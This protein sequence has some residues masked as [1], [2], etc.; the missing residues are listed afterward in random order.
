MT[1]SLSTHEGHFDAGGCFATWSATELAVGNALVTRRWRMESGLLFPSSLVDRQA[2][3][4]WLS[5]PGSVPA[6]YPCLPM[7]GP[8]R[9]VGVTARFGPHGPVEMPSLLVKVYV[10]GAALTLTYHLQVFPDSS[11]IT[12]QLL[13]EGDSGVPVPE[14]EATASAATGIETTPVA[15]TIA[16]CQLDALECLPLAPQHLRLTQVIFQDQTDAHNELVREQEWL[17]HPSERGLAL[18]GNLFILEDTLTNHGLIL[19]KAAPLPHA[20]PCKSEVDFRVD[21][22]RNIRFLGHGAGKDGDG[23]YRFAVIPYAG[24]R[25]GC[26][27]ALQQYQR[28][29]RPYQPGRDGQFL[30]NTWGD[31]SRDS[32]IREEFILTEIAAGA[33]LG[34]D[35]VQI[36]D[37]WQ[38][39]RTSNSSVAGGVWEG[40]W[41][42]DARFWQPHAE[43]FPRGLAPVID[44]A[45]A[46]GMQFGLWFAP[47]SAEDFANWE[48]DAATILDLHRVHGVRYFKID[49]VKART[50][51]GE[52]HLHRF[53]DAV[54]SASRGGIV[55]DLDVTAEERPGYFGLLDAG[56]LF[57]ENRYTDWHS[58]WPHQTLRNLW[59]LARY[60][61][62]ARLRMELLNHARHAHL[63][64]DDPLAPACYRP[65][66][67]FAVTMFAN[68]L[69]WFEVSN[70][71]E[72]YYQEA[73]P[74]IAVW[75]A[76]RDTLFAGTIYPIGQA[77]DGVSWTGFLSLDAE[78]GHGYLLVFR[79]RHPSADWTTDLAGVAG[80]YR[81]VPLAGDGEA[82]LLDGWLSVHI[83]APQ[84]YLFIRL[85]AE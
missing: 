57:V 51:Q 71:P 5:G 6:P 68:P 2:G 10:H 76:H 41:G 74:L 13:M 36:D 85:I 14:A 40:F 45:R 4:E 15:A 63:Y 25:A 75:R 53:F 28:Q 81:C 49:G 30:S 72:A 22:A 64:L 44:A 69:G 77:P 39:G 35:V 16:D 8:L 34:V 33:R 67:L 50:K 26:T 23:S 9:M 31:R 79:E 19:L 84:R 3:R 58:Y 73:G 20:R 32:R 29:F 17:L 47:D 38:H 65:D 66:Y 21:G 11:G 60:V 80:D 54:L 7:T 43:R 70:L 78:T 55:F 62:P 83:P 42:A 24:G 48:R 82:T 61:D 18:Q 37:G 27:R 52:I 56:P 59:R 1:Q 46:H 12:V